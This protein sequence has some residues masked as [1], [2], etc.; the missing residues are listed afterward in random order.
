MLTADCDLLMISGSA[1]LATTLDEQNWGEASSIY[2]ID[3][4]FV[5]RPG[6]K[7]PLV[8]SKKISIYDHTWWAQP[9]AKQN[10]KTLDYL[11]KRQE[12]RDSQE[13]W[14]QEKVR[15]GARGFWRRL[16]GR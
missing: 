12:R 7:Q 1:N 2:E 10:R 16:M 6:A 9:Q 3:P 5:F 4:T 13:R 8:E 11:V 14:R 15:F